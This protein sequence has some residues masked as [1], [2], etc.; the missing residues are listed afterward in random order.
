MILDGDIFDEQVIC[1]IIAK[2]ARSE[3]II[4]I[5]AI[6]VLDHGNIEI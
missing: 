6:F 5:D 2:L 1:H 3:Q 4:E